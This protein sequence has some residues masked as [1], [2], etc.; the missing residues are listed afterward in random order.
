MSALT[1]AAL[2]GL[3]TGSRSTSGLAALTLTGNSSAGPLGSPWARRLA[4][5]AAAGELLG[6]K[7]PQ[8]PS[9]LRPEGLVPRLAFGALA[10]AVLTH[11]EGGSRGRTALAASLG[12]AGAGAGSLLGVSW[13]Q[14]ASRRFGKDLPGALIEDACTAA[15]VRYASRARG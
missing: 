15:V 11:R 6:D 13:R 5:V 3:A 10:G 1:R 14:A 8:A 12:L 7:L 9:R 2:L 4:R